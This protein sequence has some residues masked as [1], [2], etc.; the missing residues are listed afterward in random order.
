MPATLGL[1]SLNTAI[2]SGGTRHCTWMLPELVVE[3]ALHIYIK[4]DK[5]MQP[6]QRLNVDYP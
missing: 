3:V 5:V 2:D 1:I 4:W 6:S